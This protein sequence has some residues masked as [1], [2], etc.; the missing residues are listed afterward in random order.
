MNKIN[1]NLYTFSIF[2]IIHPTTLTQIDIERSSI[3]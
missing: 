2:I 1:K 3:A